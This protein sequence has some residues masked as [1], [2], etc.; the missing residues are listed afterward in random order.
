MLFRSAWGKTTFG[1]QGYFSPGG[2]TD[3]KSDA[4]FDDARKLAEAQYAYARFNLERATRLPADFSWI[5]RGI[6]QVATGNL[7][8]SEQLGMGGY[9]TARG[10]EERE[11]NGDQGWFVSNELRSPPFS[12]LSRFSKRITLEEKMQLLMN[13]R[14][15]AAWRKDGDDLFVAGVPALRIWSQGK[16]LADA[17]RALRGAVI[18]YLKHCYRRKILDNVLNDHGFEFTETSEVQPS[19]EFIDVRECEDEKYPH[20]YSFDVPFNLVAAAQLCG[21]K[22]GGSEARAN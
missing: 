12:L 14:L 21:M 6:V 13:F 18:M 1:L 19:G 9:A 7:L 2:V 16:T 4:A 15:M 20:T 5:V 10:Y 3:L 17:T 8:A 11:G 22:G